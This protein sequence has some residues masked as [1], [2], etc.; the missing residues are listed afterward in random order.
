MTGKESP[1]L[2][3]SP[4][5]YTVMRNYNG[6][7]TGELFRKI[8]IS[9]TTIRRIKR[10][11]DLSKKPEIREYLKKVPYLNF[12][13]VK[14]LSI[15]SSG[16]EMTSKEISLKIKLQASIVRS[17]LTRLDILRLIKTN[18]AHNFTRQITKKGLRTLEAYKKIFKLL[19]EIK[20]R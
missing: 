6:E 20:R 12:S 7:S 16:R 17:Y 19:K 13:E 2:Y 3:W 15:L 5:V 1:S 9:E 18:P 10:Y 4:Q 8:G 14:I 11:Y